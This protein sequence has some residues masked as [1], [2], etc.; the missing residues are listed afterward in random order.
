MELTKGSQPCTRFKKK[1]ATIGLQ[2]PSIATHSK[3]LASS[4][5][6]SHKE[7]RKCESTAISVTPLLT[8]AREAQL[9]VK[10]PKA[11]ANPWCG[12]TTLKRLCDSCQRLEHREFQKRRTD[13]NE[14]YRSKAWRIVRRE[15]LQ[16]NRWCV[17]CQEN[18]RF[19]L[20]QV[21]DHKIP[22][23]ERPDLALEQSNLSCLCTRH[24]NSKTAKELNWKRKR[25]GGREAN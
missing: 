12:K 9:P 1:S 10:Q 21:V 19:T 15:A 14:F 17:E 2:S 5:K 3:P 4:Q 25:G 22:R 20:A 8:P 23:R 6:W 18:G 7:P 24:H 16:Q 13:G 11:C